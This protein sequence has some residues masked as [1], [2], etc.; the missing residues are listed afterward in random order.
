MY[1]IGYFTIETVC[2]RS[3]LAELSRIHREFLLLRELHLV[4]PSKTD[5]THGKKRAAIRFYSCWG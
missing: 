2:L 3:K 5:V 4:L 1:D